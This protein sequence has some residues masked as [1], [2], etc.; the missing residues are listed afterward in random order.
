MTKR[1]VSV[2]LSPDRL[3]RAQEVSGTSNLS[4]LLDD[5]LGALIERALEQQWLDAH[6]AGEETADLP[7]EVLVD[8]RAVPWD[9]P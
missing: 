6:P 2:T 5:A 8:L 9:D 3:R 4:E 1:K 7:T